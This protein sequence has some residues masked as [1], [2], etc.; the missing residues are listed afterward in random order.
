M[1]ICTNC[2][3]VEIIDRQPERC[4]LCGAQSNKIVQFEIGNIKGSK[5]IKNLQGS[6]V[7][8]SKAHQRNLAFAMKA[9]QENY[10]QIAKLFRAI[11]EAEAIHAYHD[12]HFLGVISETQTN[13]EV[14]FE[15]E[16][17]ATE[18][19]PQFV[20][21]ANEEGNTSVAKMFSQT[22]DVERTHAQ[23]YEKALEHMLADTVTDY[24][25]CSVCGWVSDGFCPDSCPVCGAPESSF[26][27]IM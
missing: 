10:P 1:W 11:A 7:A 14:A 17:L 23:L 5:T 21:E 3:H 18:S 12:M 8:E 22:R 20:K 15:R 24:Y 16:N 6:F 27:L 4:Q 25:V 13:L 2:Q 19:Y 26:K 9:E